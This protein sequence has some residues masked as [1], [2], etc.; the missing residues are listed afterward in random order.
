[1]AAFTTYGKTGDAYLDGILSGYKWATG[2]LTYSFPADASFYDGYNTTHGE[3]TQNFEVLNATQ[4]AAVTKILGMYSAV[5]NIGF[6]LVTETASQHG[7]LRFG[8]SDAAGT[9]FAYLPHSSSMGGD[10]WYNNSTGNYDNPVLGNYA[11]QTFL[12]EIGHALG[13][14][15]P[16]SDDDNDQA[17]PAD[18]DSMEWTV[19][20]Y[21]SSTSATFGGY[22]NETWSYAQTLMVWDI[23]AMQHMYGANFTS[24]SGST[25]YKWNPNTGEM[26]I[27]GIGQG[28]PGGNRV[29]QTVWDG[30]GIDTYDFS[31]YSAD[32]KVDLRPGE[33][34]ITSDA[35]IARLDWME[36]K[37]VGNIANALQYNGDAR[38]LIENAVGGSGDDTITGNQANNTL[39]GGA[40]KD[41]LTGGAGDDV[42]DGGLGNDTA[43]FSGSRLDYSVTLLGDGS[44]D[45]VDL[46]SASPDG[47]DLLKSIE[48]FRFSDRTY[49]ANE[50]GGE[51]PPTDPV[52]VE[53]PADKP[54]DP[55]PVDP[56]DPPVTP[57]PPPPPPPVGRSL[58]G[59]KGNDTISTTASKS[60]L[61]VTDGSD[62]IDGGAGTD[63]IYAGGGDDV[64]RVYAS[65]GLKDTIRAGETGEYHGDTLELMSSK[66]YLAGFSAAKSEV[67][68]LKGNGRAILGSDGS[69]T[70][71]F[72]SL[73][74]V[75][76]L[77][78]VDGGKGNDR[79]IGSLQNDTFRGGDGNDW[80][81][82]WLGSDVLTGG[83]GNDRFVFSADPISAAK[84]RIT[85]FGD[86]SGN[87]DVIDLSAV[88]RVSKGGFSAWKSQHV[89][90]VG[91]DAVISF[92]DDQIVLSKVKVSTLDYKD[93]D[94]WA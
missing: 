22:S 45:V 50:F 11:F 23:A 93:F 61:R 7:D 68:H 88:F 25:T 60:S 30:G 44:F 78:Y 89:K 69:D 74:S 49:A 18:R 64:I 32:L 28:T 70:F 94:L 26:S 38:S 80:I 54:V 19:M 85:D 43:V 27:D 52:V 63:K 76:R 57:P 4:Q 75:S 92:G 51:T 1:M 3:Q 47:H 65:E 21:K 72:G 79:F 84:D 39:E 24:Y 91:K 5:A 17:M 10:S 81:N 37:A 8:M 62:T 6:S 77:A 33:W 67:E 73:S 46:R 86:K 29:F 56:V 82:G 35:Q 15:H 90:Q 31:S 58:K 34:T 2:T 59:T 41:T 16:H 87:E 12:H 55:P 9:A 14:E 42:I 83:K 71:D 53:P 20:S 66:V 40:G 36:T 48:Y 13:L